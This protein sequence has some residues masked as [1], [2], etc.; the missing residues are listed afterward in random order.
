MNGLFLIL[1]ALVFFMW[2]IWTIDKLLNG[3]SK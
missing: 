2:V 1:G 3:R